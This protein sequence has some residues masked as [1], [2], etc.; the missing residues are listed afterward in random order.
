M[1]VGFFLAKS[2]KHRQV[3]HARDVRIGQLVPQLVEIL[4]GQNLK[5]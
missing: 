2:K 1:S 3:V 4:Q 5:S